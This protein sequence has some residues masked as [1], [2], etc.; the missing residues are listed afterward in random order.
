MLALKHR[1][2]D[3]G[4]STPVDHPNEIVEAVAD[5]PLFSHIPRHETVEILGTFDEQ[6]FSPGHRVTLEGLRG[7]DFYVIANGQAG[8]FA[9][10]RR[11][12]ELGPGDCFGEM[13]VLSDGMRSATV[14]A[15]TPLRCLVLSNDGLEKLLVQHPRLGVN[16]LRVVVARLRQLAD[17]PAITLRLVDR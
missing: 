11:V 9:D 17:R 10:G 6:S 8:V 1:P 5:A 15:E 4:A 13:A 2:C 3:G 7:S 16:L 14:T 12:A